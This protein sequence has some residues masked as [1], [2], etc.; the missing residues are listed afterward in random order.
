M[1]DRKGDNS[2]G[3]DNSYAAEMQAPHGGIDQ[4][5]P[6]EMNSEPTQAA[7][8]NSQNEDVSIDDLPF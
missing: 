7:A 1:L 2:A 6:E 8:V 5:A 3:M 4:S